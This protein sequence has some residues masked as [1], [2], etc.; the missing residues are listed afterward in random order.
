MTRMCAMSIWL[1]TSPFLAPRD[2]QEKS[3]S[4]PLPKYQRF[5]LQ[6]W[7]GRGRGSSTLVLYWLSSFTH[8]PAGQSPL[9]R[10]FEEIGRVCIFCWYFQ[11]LR[12]KERG[13]D[14]I[15]IRPNLSL[16]SLPQLFFLILF[17]K[18]I[19][20]VFIY[21]LAVLGLRFCARAFSSCGKWGPL[22][23]A[24]RGPLT[25]TASLVAEH[26]LQTRRLSSC[27]SRA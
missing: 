22:F 20:Y 8:I 16:L 24:V 21:L 4:L 26:R 17:F 13:N 15:N 18:I 23:I 5:L 11:E 7:L 10:Q 2:P 27:G 12:H 25:I 3:S 1:L 14:I 6:E 9:S 19:I